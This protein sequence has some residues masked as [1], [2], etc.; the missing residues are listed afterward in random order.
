MPNPY[1][2]VV[3]NKPWGYEYLVFE[4]PEVALWLLHIKKGKGTSLHCHPM[5]TTGLI[6]LEGEAELGFIADSKVI[7]APSKQM[8]RRGLF[9]STTA[10]SENGILLLEIE[11]PN[12]KQDLVRLA[13]DYGR[14][15]KG[16][17]SKNEWTPKDKTHIWIE[18]P[19][20]KETKTYLV[21]KTVL[22]VSRIAAI[23]DFDY[24]HDEEIVMFLKGGIGKAI[25]GR[26]HLAT[27]PGDVGIASIVKKVAKEMEYCAADTIVL[28][29][30]FNG[31]I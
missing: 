6:L 3:V 27:V 11:T 15:K 18:E 28:R 29:V 30:G 4:T 1:Q 12:D 16:Y 26:N 17:E 14:S 21:N 5:K 20:P 7:K 24:F 23:S 13:D 8:I 22:T 31:S 19:K 2:N 9:H 10:I 25:D